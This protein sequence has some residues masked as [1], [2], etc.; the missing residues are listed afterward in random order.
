MKETLT[1][2]WTKITLPIIASIITGLIVFTYNQVERITILESD[3]KSINEKVSMNREATQ[4]FLD[5]LKEMNIGIT[6]NSKAILAMEIRV[7]S[8]IERNNKM[9][10]A[11]L[12]KVED[13]SNL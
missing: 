5:V 6:D 1:M 4:E 11:L 10:E 3:M 7:D 2:W 8:L 9:I 12:R 13:K